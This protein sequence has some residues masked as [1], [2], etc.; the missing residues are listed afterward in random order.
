MPKDL[1]P[2]DEQPLERDTIVVEDTLLRQGF[3]QVPNLILRMSGVSHG[4]KLTYALLLSYAWQE[5]SCFP[6]QDQLAKDLSVERKAVIRYL[7]ELKDKQII[8]VV[9]RGMGKTNV[10]ILP[11]LSDVPKMGHQEVPKMGPVE[12]PP[13]GQY[14]YPITNTQKEEYNS[15]IRKALPQKEEKNE[16]EKEN[17]PPIEVPLTDSTHK[18]PQHRN[19]EKET[20][21]GETSPAKLETKVSSPVSPPGLTRQYLQHAKAQRT[22]QTHSQGL[23]ALSSLLPLSQ[24]S[25]PKPKPQK[26]TYSQERQVLVDMIADLAREFHDEA[27]LTESV[28]RAYNLMGKAGIKDI[29]IFTAKIYEARA[30]TMERYGTIKRGRMPY[31]FSVLAD[32]CGL[33]ANP[34]ARANAAS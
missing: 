6:G 32:V 2:H 10:Y 13:V 24:Q 26:R 19:P 25:L 9:R 27:T 14:K 18:L 22:R 8:Q 34:Q 28:S 17:Q 5:G 11:R 21:E 16:E 4:A 3:T 33:R 15:S 12:V 20:R 30:I 29:G 31:F 7:K 1:D 23:V